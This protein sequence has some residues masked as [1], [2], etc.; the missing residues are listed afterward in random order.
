[1]MWD[2]FNAITLAFW[3]YVLIPFWGVVLID[4]FKTKRQI[5]RDRKR[6]DKL[7]ADTEA[8]L[9]KYRADQDR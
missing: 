7:M 9:E 8:A 6:I 3:A 2:V 4:W 1:M 5:R